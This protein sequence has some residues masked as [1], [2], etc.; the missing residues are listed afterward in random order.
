MTPDPCGPECISNVVETIR[1]KLNEFQE[2][3]F[4]AKNT[5]IG[6]LISPVMKHEDIRQTLIS[7]DVSKWCKI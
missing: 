4:I 7:L 2:A 5:P 6:L 1:R 3:A